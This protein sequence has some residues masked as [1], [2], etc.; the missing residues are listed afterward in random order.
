MLRL[1]RTKS[2]ASLD[3]LNSSDPSRYLPLIDSALKLAAELWARARNMGPLPADPRELNVDI[4]IAAQVLDYQ[5]TSGIPLT[6]F[7]V[8]TVNV[9][10]LS[11]FVPAD[12][13]ANI[14]P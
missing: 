10:H 2:I 6:D 11:L 7:I 3:A 1:G 8:A 5:N 4:L 13:W 9:G 12:L 14:K